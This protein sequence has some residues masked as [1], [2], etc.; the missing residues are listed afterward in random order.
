M[1][2]NLDITIDGGADFAFNFLIKIG[3]LPVN[4]TG[5]T[6]VGQIK[7]EYTSRSTSAT[8]TTIVTNASAGTARLE[9]GGDAT[10]ALPT[11]G[12]YDVLL[13]DNGTGDIS[14]LAYGKV[15]TIPAVSSV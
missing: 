11:S 10:R 1:A 13:K 2:T 15:T 6:I 7:S 5:K 12:V 3:T 4:L 8:F 14:K 9:L